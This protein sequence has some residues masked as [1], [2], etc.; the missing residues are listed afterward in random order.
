MFDWATKV[1]ANTS[2]RGTPNGDHS[3][4][5]NDK[6]ESDHHQ[7]RLWLAPAIARSAAGAGGA[8]R[9]D[10]ALLPSDALKKNL[11]ERS[12]GQEPKV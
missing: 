12:V 1:R 8:R 10:V 3:P 9:R 6:G 7:V 2:E 5:G 11:G 4:R